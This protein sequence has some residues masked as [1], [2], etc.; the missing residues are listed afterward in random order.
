MIFRLMTHDEII[1][2]YDTEL[3]R[4]FVPQECKPL[5]DIFRLIEENR[6]EIW[7]L[8]EESTLLGYACLWKSPD[9]ELVLLDYLGVT[10]ARRNEGLGSEILRLLQQQGR[11]LVTES[12]LPVCTTP[13]PFPESSEIL[14]A[15]PVLPPSLPAPTAYR[16]FFSRNQRETYK[17]LRNVLH[18]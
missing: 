13:S 17:P 3:T 15:Q 6:Y 11:P 4:T 5:I 12:E 18:P 16:Y 7:G 14:S 2:W 1:L 10:A 8:F 9:M